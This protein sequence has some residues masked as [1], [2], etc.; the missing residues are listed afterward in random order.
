MVFKGMLGLDWA[1]SRG[2]LCRDWS[3]HVLAR[4]DG[5]LAGQDRPAGGRPG[6]RPRPQRRAPPRELRRRGA[7]E[8]GRAGEGAQA[9]RRDPAGAS[10]RRPRAGPHDAE[11]HGRPDRAGSDLQHVGIRRPRSAGAGRARARGPDRRDDADERRRDPALDRLPRCAHRA[12]RRL[13]GRRPGRVVHVSL[14]GKRPGRVHVPL[15]HEAR[16]RAHRQ[17][18]VRRDRRQPGES[19]AEGRPRVRAR[20]ERVVPERRRHRGAGEPRHGEGARDR[21]RLDDLQRLREPVR[22]PS[23]DGRPG[24]HR[25]LLGS[26]RQARRSTRTSTS[27][28]RSSTAPG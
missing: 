2:G 10:V 5:G 21:T 19:P 4:L 6:S 24:R 27:S 26:S 20:C 23:A 7:G 3:R 8:R 1:R 16:P 28:G 9:V 22:D 25:A 17:R 12:E 14:Q 18:H 11:G 15:R 13:Q